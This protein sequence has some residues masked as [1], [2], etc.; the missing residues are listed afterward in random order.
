MASTKAAAPGRQAEGG[1]E[2]TA[3]EHV[4]NP[5]YIDLE[6]YLDPADRL[7]LA[8]VRSGRFVL[9]VRCLV[10]GKALT[11]KRSRA[12]GVGPGCRRKAGDRR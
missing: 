3:A 9:A 4:L 11:S 10:C 8:A 7:A 6:Q 2:N 1:R 5:E 12:L